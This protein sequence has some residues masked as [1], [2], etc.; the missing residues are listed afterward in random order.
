MALAGGI[1]VTLDEYDGSLP[2]HAIFFGEDQGRYLVAS[3]NPDEIVARAKGSG[4]P[5]RRIGTTHGDA[6]SLPG[7]K[8]IPLSRIR[9]LHEGWLPDYMTSQ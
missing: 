1:G 9:D 5:C 6:I 8:D 2:L 4:I 7:E 3:N